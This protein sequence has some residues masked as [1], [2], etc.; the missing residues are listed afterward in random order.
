MPALFVARYR[1]SVVVVIVERR[2]GLRASTAVREPPRLDDRKRCSETSDRSL[3]DGMA[4][5]SRSN[6][7][8]AIEANSLFRE[9]E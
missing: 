6:R 1:R 4:W 9:M 2:G 8:E 5:C 3:F 7:S